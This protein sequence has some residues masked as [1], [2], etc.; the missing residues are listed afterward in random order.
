MY[1]IGADPEIFLRNHNTGM[2]MSAADKIGGTKGHP[3]DLGDGFGLQE[4]NVMVEFNI[5]PA[6]S[7]RNFMRLIESGLDRVMT[8]VGEALPEAEFDTAAERLF[9]HDLLQS[10][11]AQTFGC[12]PDFDAYSQGV[13]CAKITPQL[14]EREEGAWR[15]AG[16]HVH[17]GY[18]RK[19]D[20]P[21]YVVAQF[22][23]LYLG[24]PSIG[25]DVQTHRRSLYGQAGRYRPTS[26]G[27]EYRVL[28]NFWVQDRVLLQHV[29]SQASALLAWIEA[30]PVAEIQQRYKAVP[31]A[32]VR[33]AINSEDADLAASLLRW[34]DE[35]GLPG[36]AA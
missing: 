36:M 33:Q 5:P 2:V 13:A 10:Q 35:E 21:D 29:A 19:A 22:A 16:G 32:E 9:P 26:Y 27:I 31:W 24:L 11:K 17:M 12:S 18:G 30:R 3:L 7:A 20:I 28:S 1:T 15:F 34:A 23:D 6:Q 14:L 25:T 4:D 8:H